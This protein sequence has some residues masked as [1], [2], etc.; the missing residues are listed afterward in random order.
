M[1]AWPDVATVAIDSAT[2]LAVMWLF[3]GRGE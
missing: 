1:S 2:F 3:F